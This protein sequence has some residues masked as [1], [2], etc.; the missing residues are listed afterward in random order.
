MIGGRGPS[1]VKLRWHN[2]KEY[3]NLKYRKKFDLGKW[4]NTPEGTKTYAK[5]ME[6]YCKATGWSQGLK[7]Q[8]RISKRLLP[9]T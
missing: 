1:G 4:R 5:G 2:P 9:R 8:A 3:A 7:E 6:V